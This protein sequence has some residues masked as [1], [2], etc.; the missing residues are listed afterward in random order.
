LT[1]PA[2]LMSSGRRHCAAALFQA[3]VSSVACVAGAAR[4][5][6]VLQVSFHVISCVAG[7]I[8]CHVICCRCG[9][10][11]S[12][13]HARHLQTCSGPPE[14][15][16]EQEI[17]AQVNTQQKTDCNRHA[18]SFSAAAAAAAA[19][20]VLMRTLQRQQHNLSAAQLTEPGDS[21]VC[22]RWYVFDCLSKS[23]C[24][25]CRTCRLRSTST[26]RRTSCGS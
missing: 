6:H 23:C 19:A 11:L 5:C 14:P 21:P 3:S 8:S 13:G 20:M 12:A 7:V 1:K 17:A 26:S 24:C 2:S 18:S 15:P 4:C 16:T 10:V 9:E 22:R 25:K